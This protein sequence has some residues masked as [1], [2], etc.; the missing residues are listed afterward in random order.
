[1]HPV[2]EVAL[3][4]AAQAARAITE[5]SG[6]NAHDVA[7][8]LGSG[9]GEAADA[10]GTTTWQSS[11]SE[12]PHF[13]TPQ[14]GGHAGMV[15]SIDADGRRVLAFLGRV[16][17][18][19]EVGVDAVGHAVRT[20]AAAGCRVVVLTNSAGALD[21]AWTPGTVVAISDHVN[22][23]GTSPLHGPHFVDL[24]DLYAPRLRTLCH[25]IA[26]GMPDGVYV[27]L[28]GPMYETPAEIRMVEA[29]GGS[30]V[31][32][33]TALEAIVA[34]SV[35]LEVAGLSLVTNAA[36][37]LA[38]APLDHAEVLATGQASVGRMGA[39]LA[40]LVRRA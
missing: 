7:V 29:I 11:V 13:A 19:D 22:L 27:Q 1:M 33:S 38:G 8:V 39:L 40:D 18:Y 26:G 16:H 31:G 30:L 10:I 23:T 2:T 32:M 25:E 24:T 34:R 14:A 4:H 21:R 9:W 17:L 5:A 36:A 15:R 35:G 3:Q 12:L 28:R 37:G 6:V 20:A